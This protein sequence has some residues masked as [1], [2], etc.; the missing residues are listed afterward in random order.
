M[1]LINK[2]DNELKE[3]LA[4]LHA[5][6]SAKTVSD[7]ISELE[8]AASVCDV[9]IKKVE[10]RR[11]RI[12][13]SEHRQSLI[14]QINEAQDDPALTLHLSLL[15]LFQTCTKEI[16]H[17]SGKFVPQLI[18]FLKPQLEPSTYDL[19]HECEE[20]V[21][22]QLS[23]KD[24]KATSELEEQESITSRLNEIASKIKAL[25]LSPPKKEPETNQ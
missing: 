25:A 17:A 9:M 22:K 12:I 1:K 3:P 10:K 15:L 6:L 2:M 5:S 21:V 11:E 19:L 14:L 13:T 20:L 24:P 23:M 4:K 8:N 7:F 18:S 16:V